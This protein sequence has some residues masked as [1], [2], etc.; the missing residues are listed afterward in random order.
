MKKKSSC[1]LLKPVYGVSLQPGKKQNL[2]LRSL[3]RYWMLY[4]MLLPGFLY[5]L[6]NNYLPIGG[7]VIAFK[8]INLSKG[9]FGSDWCGLKNFEFL[10]KT[11]D[12]WIITRN[13][14]L[15]N[16]A[17]YVINTV[18]ALTVAILLNE[19]RNKFFKNAFQSIV[20]LPNLISWVIVGYLGY[21]FLSSSA[22]WLNNSFLPALGLS[23]VS[24]YTD[25]SKWPVILM[26]TQNWKAAGY[27]SIVY[28]SA[29]IG[30]D[31]SYYEAASV[32]GASRWKQIRHITLPMLVPVIITMLLLSATR[33]FYS[34]FGLFYQLPQA[35]NSGV[36]YRAT[37]TI[38]VYVY[39]A[40]LKTGNIGMSSAAGFFQSVVSFI[41]VIIANLSVRRRHPEAVIF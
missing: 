22:G 6:V 8:N 21:A 25:I 41:I 9:I 12:A 7:L 34:D 31:P 24:W 23:K 33:I 11:N 38:D 4:A 5:L 14:I 39:N 20:M 1:T 15:Y 40:I 16:L 27:L 35:Q 10:F 2:F 32:D 13:T 3:K 28:F 36:L 26:F 19:M 18:F 17:F 37:G 30:I 29:V